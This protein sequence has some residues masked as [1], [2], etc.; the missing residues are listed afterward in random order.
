MEFEIER[1]TQR[2]TL[3]LNGGDK[4]SE[5]HYQILYKGEL[6]GIS[7]HTKT[8]GSPEYKVVADELHLK[9]DDE[10]AWPIADIVNVAQMAIDRGIW[11]PE[12]SSSDD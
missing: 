9:G 12:E 6:T 1:F 3:H 2:M 5:L 10:G 7:R 8:N 11:K 4:Y